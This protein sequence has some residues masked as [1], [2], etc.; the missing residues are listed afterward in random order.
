MFI[1]AEAV[2]TE[3]HARFPDLVEAAQQAGMVDFT[4]DDDGCANYIT[5]RAPD[6]ATRKQVHIIQDHLV[7][8]SVSGFNLEW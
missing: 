4:Y 2:F 1:P 8:L 5:S 7:A 6:A 3:I